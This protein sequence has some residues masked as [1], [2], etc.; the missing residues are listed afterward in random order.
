M[1][2]AATST[3]IQA[4]SLR[5]GR[6]AWQLLLTWLVLWVFWQTYTVW[7]AAFLAVCFTATLSGLARA[8]SRRTSWSYGVSLA[9]V[10]VMIALALTAAVVL[11][12]PPVV[13][14]AAELTERLPASVDQ[15][16]QW[17]EQQTPWGPYVLERSAKWSESMAGNQV[18]GRLTSVASSVLAAGA[19][20]LAVIAIT[21]LLA[22]S[23]RAYLKGVVMLVPQQ[24]ERRVREV[25]KRIGVA[26]RW[27]LFGQAI[28]MTIV[29]VFTG[30]GLMLVGVPLPW[31]LGLIAGVFSFVPNLGPIVAM[32]PGL[33]LAS[34]EGGQTILW[35]LG[36]YVGVQLIESN[37]VTPMVQ[38]YAVSVP[39]ALLLTL[40]LMMG[41]LFG[42]MG[43]LVATPL[44]VA[45]IVALQMLYVED[46]LDR[47]VEVMGQHDDAGGEGKDKNKAGDSDAEK[48]G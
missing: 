25:C 23:P 11:F 32:A 10:V 3:D 45:V 35:A 34:S 44:M 27:W 5:R 12:G 6:L 29:G 40:Q 39:P 19:G 47:D 17:L 43:L 7:F 46:K 33:V 13:K 2:K 22:L 30:L 15:G 28:S 24:H 20:I 36:V 41:V 37:V 38:K 14:Q 42:V 18:L 1:N 4:I 48:E 26:L 8:L 9:A 31:A 21:L 16:K